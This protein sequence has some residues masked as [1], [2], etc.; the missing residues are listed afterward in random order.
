MLY[1]HQIK[2]QLQPILRGVIAHLLY[3]RLRF[4]RRLSSVVLTWRVT[5][6]LFTQYDK[7]YVA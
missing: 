3:R 5:F 6:F 2:V 1:V 7:T 4:N